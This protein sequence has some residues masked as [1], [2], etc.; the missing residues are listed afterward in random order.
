MLKLVAV[1]AFL[2][3]YT[4]PAFVSDPLEYFQF[5]VEFSDEKQIR[6]GSGTGSS[7]PQQRTGQ[8]SHK[9]YEILPL[10]PHPQS[11]ELRLHLRQTLG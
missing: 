2:L 4:F 7:V 5:Q 6:S 11:F 8:E 10:Q 9:K 3:P 1:I